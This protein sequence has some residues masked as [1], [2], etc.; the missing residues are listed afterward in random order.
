MGVVQLSPS[1]RDLIDKM[2]LLDEEHRITLQEVCQQSEPFASRTERVSTWTCSPVSH[3]TM[4]ASQSP[5]VK[6]TFD[7]RRNRS[8][9]KRQTD[10]VV[11]VFS[12]CLL[13]HAGQ[14]SI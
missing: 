14:C 10:Y 9:D 7:Q 8:F 1:C 6:H 12:I 3:K 2:L 13:E 5:N 11:L 4:A